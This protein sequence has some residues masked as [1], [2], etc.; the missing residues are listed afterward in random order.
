MSWRPIHPEHAIERVRVIAQLSESLPGELVFK[1]A[2]D[3]EEKRLKFGFQEQKV[4]RGQMV[5]LGPE[6]IS[7]SG[8]SEESFAWDWIRV[9]PDNSPIEKITVEGEYISY[10][11]VEY[12]GWSEFFLRYHSINKHLLP[13]AINLLKPASLCLEYIDKVVF[14]GDPND[15]APTCV[16]EMISKLIPPVVMEGSFLWHV[17][18]GW[19]EILNGVPLLINQNLEAHNAKSSGDREFRILQFLTKVEL[20]FGGNT[21]NFSNLVSHLEDM[22]EISKKVFKSSLTDDMAVKVGLYGDSND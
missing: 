22:H 20:R 14:D 19:Y 17:H 4:R 15:A 12:P 5:S 8:D 3:N 11:T 21:L 7:F 6:G 16:S 1:L 2:K 18:R 9:S 13:E 10:E